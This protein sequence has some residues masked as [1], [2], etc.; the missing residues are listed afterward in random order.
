GNQERVASWH[1]TVDSKSIYQHV[2]TNEVAWHAGTK[3]GNYSSIGIEIC[4]NQDGNKAKANVV[5]LIQYLM[6]KHS[7]PISHVVPHKHWSGK[8]CPINLLK[9]WSGFI[10]Q[11]QGAEKDVSKVPF[12]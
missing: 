5:E 3:E 7:I 9:N 6:K 2:P 1:F 12:T 4:V 11:V 10:S 8:Q